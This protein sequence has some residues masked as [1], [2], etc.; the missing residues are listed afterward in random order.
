MKDELNRHTGNFR[1]LGICLSILLHTLLVGA[2]VFLSGDVPKP[3]EVVSI[4]LL[5]EKPVVVPIVP[6]PPKPE[7]PKPEP[8][9]PEPPK[10]EPP[11]PEP[12]KPEPP[13]PQ[14]PKPELPKPQ[15][16]KPQP[17]KPQPPKPQQ[18]Q[19]TTASLEDRLG[20]APTVKDNPKPSRKN[21]K[22]I[23]EI[24]DKAIRDTP[25][26]DTPRPSG[27]ATVAEAIDNYAEKVAK[28]YVYQNWIQ[29]VNGELDVSNVLP[30]TIGFTVYAGGSVSNARIVKPSNSRVMN[31]SVRNMLA[32]MKRLQPFANLGIKE[33][34]L[35]ITVDVYLTR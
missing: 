19:K 1:G 24:L 21:N 3:N 8:P 18:S 10:P 20:S 13:K 29:P 12:P 5:Q 14:P 2:I 33:S 27:G 22:N 31:E 30:V 6:E 4:S 26:K 23:R 7:P 16:P 35:D 9:K 25:T 17:P 15:P 32:Q 28:P 11:K 34:K